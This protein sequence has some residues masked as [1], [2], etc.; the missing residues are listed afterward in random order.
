MF[1][2]LR[3]KAND[4]AVRAPHV[5][6]HCFVLRVRA[7][8]LAEY[9]ARHAAVW[10]ELLCALRDTGWTRYSLFL[11]DDGLL[12]GFVEAED[13]AASAQAMAALDVNARWQAEM[14][15]YFEPLDGRRPD[16]AFLLLDEVFHLETQL[17]TLAPAGASKG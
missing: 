4:A 12:V 9:R 13:L 2:M 16:E 1:H 17:N 3:S 15:Q 8:R 14:T 6:R 5:K 7:D 10:P 11:K